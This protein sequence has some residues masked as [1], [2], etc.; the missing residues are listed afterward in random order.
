MGSRDGWAAVIMT[1]REAPAGGDGGQFPVGVS[2]G[3]GADSILKL[4]PSAVHVGENVSH[5]RM[6]F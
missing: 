3:R 1:E 4:G 2:V 6:S 5:I